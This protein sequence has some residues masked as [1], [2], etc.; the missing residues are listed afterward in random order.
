MNGHDGNIAP[1]EIASRKIK[2]KY[3]EAQIAALTQ[4]WVAAG[5]L[6]PKDT[7]E[8]W[9]GLG[10]AGEGETSIAY[11]LFPDWC[12][13]EYATCVVPNLPSEVEIKWDFQ[14]LQILPRQAMLQKVPLKKVKK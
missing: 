8:V 4:W 9:D 14:S 2:E 10:H 11:Y 6:L 1:I 7:F 3:P 13:P 12:E 5:N